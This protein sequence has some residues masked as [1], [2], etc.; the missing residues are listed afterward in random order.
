MLGIHV[1]VFNNDQWEAAKAGLAAAGHA[2]VTS[3]KSNTATFLQVLM[4]KY[5]HIAQTI[6]QGIKDM[7]DSSLSG[8]EKAVKVGLDV[9]AVLPEAIANF[10][11]IK[12]AIVAGVTQFFADEVSDFKNVASQAIDAV[13][14]AV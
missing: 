11:G 6:E 7:K 9:V 3:L 5:P 10:S 12:D 1:K 14:K 8:G 4:N 2:E 13:A